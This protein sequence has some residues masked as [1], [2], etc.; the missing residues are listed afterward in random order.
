MATLN[1]NPTRV[2]R[3]TRCHNPAPTFCATIDDTLAPTASAGICTYVHSC[4]AT[5]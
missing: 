5:P 2:M 3:D 1:I 4:D